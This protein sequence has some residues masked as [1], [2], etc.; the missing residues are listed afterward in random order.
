MQQRNKIGG[1][2]DR[3]FG[4]NDPTMAPEDK[5]LERFTREQQQRAYKSD[6]FNLED[7]DEVLTHY[8]QSLGSLKA[9]DFHEGVEEAESDDDMLR[10]AKRAHSLDGEFA[11]DED[12][13]G[14]PRKKTKTEVMKEVIAKS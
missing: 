12:E 10:L 6:I 13:N 2:I 14:P 7:D 11:R 1:I 9:D 8:G 3:R 5:M 4:E